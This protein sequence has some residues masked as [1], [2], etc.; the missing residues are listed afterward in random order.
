MTSHDD[1]NPKY[2]REFFRDMPISDEEKCENQLSDFR[3]SRVFKGFFLLPLFSALFAAFV[4]S[5]MVGVFEGFLGLLIVILFFAFFAYLFLGL[6]S[7][8]WAFILEC[9]YNKPKARR[10]WGILGLLIIVVHSYF[11]DK[12]G[13]V[14]RQFFGSS[15]V[16][17]MFIFVAGIVTLYLLRR[18]NN[19]ISSSK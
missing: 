11:F 9:L 3:W 8:I 12:K 5:I 1:K 13:E 7:L 6:Q 4:G 18:K 17:S 19:H 2:Y 15:Y 10:I 16:I 14:S